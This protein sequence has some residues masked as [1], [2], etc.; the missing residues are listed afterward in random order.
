M[1]HGIEDDGRIW[2]W[3]IMMRARII[4]IMMVYDKVQV[5]KVKHKRMNYLK[6]S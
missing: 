2:L 3:R 5:V 4:Y 1:E 6:I